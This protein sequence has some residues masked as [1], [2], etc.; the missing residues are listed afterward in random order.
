MPIGKIQLLQQI[1]RQ[2]LRRGAPAAARGPCGARVPCGT[3]GPCGAG[4]PCGAR[5]P[6]G[7]RAPAARGAHE[8]RRE[9]YYRYRECSGRWRSFGRDSVEITLTLLNTQ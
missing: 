3:R 2:I 6:C 9:N 7:A 8:V 1:H 4:V 5:G